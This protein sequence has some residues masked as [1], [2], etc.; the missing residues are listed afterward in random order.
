MTVL[1]DSWVW[2]EYFK[3]SKCGKDAKKY[4]EGNEKA[5]LSAINIAE[6]YRWILRFYDDKVAEEKKRVMKER[7][8]VIPVDEEIA[9][10]S[11]KIKHNEKM[12]LGDALIYATA[13]KENAI[14]LTGDSDFEGKDGV[15]FIGD[16]TKPV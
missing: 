15:I 5:I 10:M 9:V 12:G 2:V 16:K 8:F 7:C 3:G 1:I 4:I 13:K 14:L 6:V 11:A